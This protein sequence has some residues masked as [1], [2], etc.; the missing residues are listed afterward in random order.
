MDINIVG[1]GI[2]I[3][4]DKLIYSIYNLRTAQLLKPAH[5]HWKIGEF[6]IDRII[7]IMCWQ[8]NDIIIANHS[9]HPKQL[10]GPTLFRLV[11]NCQQISPMETDIDFTPIQTKYICQFSNS[12]LDKP[13]NSYIRNLMARKFNYSIYRPSVQEIVPIAWNEL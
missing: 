9:T 1:I 7:I 6:N 11:R 4:D 5:G 3:N 8:T 12:I 10:N 2:G 13:Y